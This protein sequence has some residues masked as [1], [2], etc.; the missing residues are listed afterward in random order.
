MYLFINQLN[1]PN[2]EF[3][4]WSTHCPVTEHLISETGMTYILY[5]PWTPC[6]WHV[7]EAET[8]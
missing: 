6:F 7:S 3:Y 5:S 4:N 2:S 1:L 8:T